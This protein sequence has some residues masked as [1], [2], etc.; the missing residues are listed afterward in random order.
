[1][2]VNQN[3]LKRKWRKQKAQ[4]RMMMRE[5]IEEEEVVKKREGRQAGRWF[6][7]EMK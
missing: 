5:K 2:G 4:Q 1:M 7:R 3:N 6:S